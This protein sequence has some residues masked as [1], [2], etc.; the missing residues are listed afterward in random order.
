MEITMLTDNFL[1]LDEIQKSPLLEPM[2]YAKAGSFAAITEI[3][4]QLEYDGRIAA[5]G[6]YMLIAGKPY[7]VDVKTDGEW[8]LTTFIGRDESQRVLGYRN[9]YGRYSLASEGYGFWSPFE[10]KYTDPCMRL[11]RSIDQA[12]SEMVEADFLKI[13]RAA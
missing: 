10:G 11:L 8:I 13:G 9:E 6:Q 4:D 2:V 7:I 12:A 3:A 5:E 1:T